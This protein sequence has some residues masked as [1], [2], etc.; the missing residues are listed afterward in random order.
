MVGAVRS[1][2]PCERARARAPRV[3][4]MPRVPHAAV[5]CAAAAAL[6]CVSRPVRCMICSWLGAN[7]LVTLAVGLCLVSR[8]A[9]AK[10][11]PC[12]RRRLVRHCHA[13]AVS[14]SPSLSLMVCASHARHGEQDSRSERVFCRRSERETSSSA[15]IHFSFLFFLFFS[16][17]FPFVVS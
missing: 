7:R 1:R 15:M 16:F 13:C 10:F 9:H 3:L 14:P 8:I 17:L 11:S 6:V 2:G 5:H 12:S 4:V